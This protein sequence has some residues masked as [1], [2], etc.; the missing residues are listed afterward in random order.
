M[1][2][3]IESFES[4]LQDLYCLVTLCFIDNLRK[5]LLLFII[6]SRANTNMLALIQRSGQLCNAL[7]STSSGRSRGRSRS[8]AGKVYA[9]Q[10]AF[11]KDKV[12]TV[13]G[14]V[15]VEGTAAV[16]FLGAGGQEITIECPKVCADTSTSHEMMLP[17]ISPSTATL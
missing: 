13:K 17:M 12:N 3:T 2:I 6:F 14:P 9:A 8:T 11:C 16:S 7:T 1:A 5:F 10:E 4:V 15:K